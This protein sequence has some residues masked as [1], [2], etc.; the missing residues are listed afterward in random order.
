MSQQT[1]FLDQRLY[2]Y[3]QAI[4]LRRSPIQQALLDVTATVQHAGIESSPEQVQFFQLLVHVMRAKRCIEV[5]VFT[6]YATLAIAME[7][8]ADGYVVACD[9]DENRTRVAQEFW[10]RAGVAHKIDLRIAP[11]AHTLDLLLRQGQAGSFDF[12]Y[13]DADKLNGS[14][15]YER[16]LLLLRVDGL[17]AIDNVFWEGLVAATDVH[18]PDTD[19]VRALNSKLASDDRVDISM[20][21][22]GDGIMLA[23]KRG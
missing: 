14:E 7:L 2:Q 11:A 4:S 22:L 10:R 6:G 3:M 9:I 18:D 12:V 17:I 1:L 8:P 19:A 15:Y 20:I 23:R 16:A 21:P 5:G 13:I